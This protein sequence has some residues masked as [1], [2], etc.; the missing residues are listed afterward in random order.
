[1]NAIPHVFRVLAGMFIALACQSLAHAAA[2]CRKVETVC[3]AGLASDPF[4]KAGV[5]TI[6]PCRSFGGDS[7]CLTDVGRTCWG[8]RSSYECRS[9]VTVND[10]KPLR[11][12]GCSQIGST[13]IASV[14][15]GKC[16]TYEQ[17]YQCTDK[18]ESFTEKTICDTSTFCQSNGVGCFDTSSKPDGDFGKSAAMMEVARQAGVYGADNLELFKGY[19]EQCSIKVLGGAT[20]KSCCNSTGGGNGFT[21][22]ALLGAGMKVAGE[23]GREGV[24]VGSKYVY[25]S[26]YGT[27]DSSLIDKGLGAMNSWAGGL[28]DGVFNPQFGFYGF[29][30][31]FTFANGFSY[32][33]F[34]PYSFALSVAIMLVQEWLSCDQSEQMMAMKRG[35]NLCVHIET[36]CSS[37]VLGICVERKERHCCF[38]SKL[39]KI[40]NWQG[41]GQLGMAMN[42]CGGFTQTQLQ[43]LDF[44]RIDMSEFIADVTPKSPNVSGMS[45]KVNQ[46]V[47]Q[48]VQSYYDQ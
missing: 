41:R 17:K 6:T 24:V 27:L 8:K 28:G 38:N 35:Q 43:S 2:D 22:F 30:F 39:A 25:D 14:D 3:I 29:T 18:A 46:T 15:G 7:V 12:R 45:D 16:A 47:Q 1:M 42:T 32:V 44:S 21:N 37:K 13:C 19:M 5:T 10:C 34:D 36:Y 20:L 11:D 48:K 23:A 26:L 31:E 33:G 40:I 4:Y 9:N